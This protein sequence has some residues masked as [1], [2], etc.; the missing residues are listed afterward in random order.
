MKVS[1]Y[2]A[3]SFLSA[4][5][6]MTAIALPAQAED[7][8]ENNVRGSRPNLPEQASARAHHVQK[9][10]ELSRVL[11]QG[12]SGKEVEDLQQFLKEEGHFDFD[13]I[14]GYFGPV[15]ERALQRFQA[16]EGIVSQG[17]PQSTG[18]GQAGPR[19]L[20]Q[21]AK[22]SCLTEGVD[23]DRSEDTD[24]KDDEDET[25]DEEET[26]EDLRAQIE[27][28]QSEIAKLQA[29]IDKLLEDENGDL[30]AIDEART[31]AETWMENESPTYSYDGENL[32]LTEEEETEA[33]VFEF[34]FE[35]QSRAGGYGD[36]EGQMVTQVITPHTTVVTVEYDEENDEYNVTSAITDEKYD[37][38]NEEMLNGDL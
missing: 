29:K 25:V 24:E 7:N 16:A 15:T 17:N 31:T 4:A 30:E 12:A 34:T 14:T 3:I 21:I 9:C 2:I 33:G 38:L 20:A 28:L 35:F 10:L 11:R 8:N 6:L 5:F 18:Y 22:K 1:K 32:E 27:V 36:R 23:R 19:T 13:Q 26:V 37:E